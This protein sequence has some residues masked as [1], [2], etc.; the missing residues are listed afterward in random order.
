MAWLCMADSRRIRK[1][2]TAILMVRSLEEIK[3]MSIY[4][5]NVAKRQSEFGRYTYL[6]LAAVSIRE[7]VDGG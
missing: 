2:R 4:S 7:P 6:R 5:S 3:Q 1:G